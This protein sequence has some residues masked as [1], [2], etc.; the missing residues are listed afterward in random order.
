VGVLVRDGGGKR[1][2][3]CIDGFRLQHLLVHSEGSRG[4][5]VR[6]HLH[7][8]MGAYQA[9]ERVRAVNVGQ[10]EGLAAS[11]AT[12]QAAQLADKRLSV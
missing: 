4:D 3:R 12:F 11:F 9:S 10:A 2:G 8:Y 7:E 5:H 1:A 6:L